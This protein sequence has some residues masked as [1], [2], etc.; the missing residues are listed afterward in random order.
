MPPEPPF[1][2]TEQSQLSHPFLIEEAL[3]T[4]YYLDGPSPDSLHY[5]HGSPVQG[6]P[7][8]DT[9]HQIWSHQCWA[10]RNDH[11]LQPVGNTLL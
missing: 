11:L 8:L 5:V 6:S 9:V 4:L 2:Q 7:K 1:L 3:Q 10:E